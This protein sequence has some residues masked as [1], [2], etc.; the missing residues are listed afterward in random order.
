M[1]R[2]R[3][4]SWNKVLHL[5]DQMRQEDCMTCLGPCVFCGRTRKGGVGLFC[6]NFLL[7]RGPFPP[8]RNV[9][10]GECYQEAIDDP[11]PRRQGM[12]REPEDPK[13]ELEADEEEERCY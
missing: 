2:Q 12:E 10:C 4:T 1:L 11:F 3:G 13:E 5:K 8:C 9:W 6:S 7:G